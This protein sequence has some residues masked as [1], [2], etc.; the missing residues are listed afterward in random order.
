M[1]PR[2]ETTSSRLSLEEETNQ[3][4]LEEE[5]K[6]EGDLVIHLLDKEDELDRNLGVRAPGLIIARIDSNLKKEEEMALNK[7]KTLK[8]LL[9]DKAKG[10]TSKDP[11]A[12][13]P[14]PILPSPSTPSSS[15][16]PI[17]YLKKMRKGKEETKKGELARQKEPKQ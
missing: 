17:P 16:L 6:E 14:L 12:P 15:L 13:Y 9:I 1:I 4:H 8:D 10:K 3:F 11:V 5:K 7:R 2:K